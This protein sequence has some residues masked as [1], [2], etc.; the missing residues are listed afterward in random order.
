MKAVVV[1]RYGA[2]E[3]FAIEELPCPQPGPGELRIRIATA[4]ISFVDLLTA[5]GQYQ[6]KPPLPYTP[7]SEIAGIVDAV[8]PGVA[9]FKVG[10]RV[11]AAS[12]TGAWAEFICV[13]E[14]WA[15]AVPE[16]LPN[17]QAAVFHVPYSTAL[18]GLQH[19][20]RLQAG[21]TLFVAGAAGSVGLAAIQV[22]KLL[23]AHV[24][25]GAS[26]ARKREAAQAAGADGVINTGAADWPKALKVAAM[27]ATAG[28]GVDV[29]FDPVGGPAAEAAFRTLAWGGRYLVVGFA[30]GTIPAI[31]A[32][33]ALLKSAALLGVNVGPFEQH[34]P[35]AARRNREQI[36]VWLKERRVAPLIARTFPLRDFVAAAQLAAERETV[37]RV[38]LTME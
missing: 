25:A 35:E 32:N 36:A 6:I 5:A 29:V 27:A 34:E 1:H 37:G 14:R 15:I 11:C 18:L 22:G 26:S 10:D 30:S 16:G 31:G 3:S 13:P 19:R 7:G 33:W 2:P 21:E 9:G 28:K 17:A 23:G 8:G 38:V 24:I 12:P 20:G 4:G